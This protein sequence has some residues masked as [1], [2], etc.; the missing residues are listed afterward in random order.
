MA[1]FGQCCCCSSPPEVS[2]AG[3]SGAGWTKVGDTCCYEQ[4]FTYNS[5]PSVRSI[6]PYESWVDYLYTG[7]GY[8][9]F[10]GNDVGPFSYSVRLAVA[11]RTLL[12]WQP[13]RIRLLAQRL[14]HSCLESSETGWVVNAQHVIG[15]ENRYQRRL[16][17]FGEMTAPCYD[18]GGVWSTTTRTTLN[19][20]SLVYDSP[21]SFNGPYG[22]HTDIASWYASTALET[23]F[24]HVAFFDE[25]PST[26]DFGTPLDLPSYPGC[27]ASSCDFLG[28]VS[29]LCWNDAEYSLQRTLL[30]SDPYIVASSRP[31][32]FGCVGGPEQF[33]RILPGTPSSILFPGAP[34]SYFMQIDNITWNMECDHV[35]IEPYT[36][37]RT[38]EHNLEINK[39][40]S[41]EN[42]LRC[43]SAIAFSV[44][45]DTNEELPAP[46]TPEEEAPP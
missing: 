34:S 28:E 11:A 44:T 37:F 29:Q 17:G 42:G 26:I 7:S 10:N 4:V 38:Q 31:T 33:V 45:L 36:I 43:D 8:V 39:S 30:S 32:F 5:V 6:G 20:G 19:V 2:I 15:F 27:V 41:E 35:V 9:C 25:W 18:L 13:R 46:E 22:P 40:I 12:V 16:Y 1:S 24:S 3:M 23:R 14:T 21:L